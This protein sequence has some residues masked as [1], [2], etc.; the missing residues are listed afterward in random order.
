MRIG[1]VY[2]QVELQGDAVAMRQFALATERIGYD[3]LVCYDHLLGASH[4]G[5]E[6]K[7]YGHY[8]EH[9]P[10]HDPFM[11]FAHVAAITERIEFVTGV[12]VLPQRQ[13]VLVA[14]QSTDLDL[15]SNQRFRL[16]VGVGWN[17]V[18][19]QGLGQDFATRGKR[20]DEQI[21]LL[22]RLWT[23]PLVTHEGRFDRID[24]AALVPRPKRTIPIWIG[25]MSEPAY[26]RAARLGD[27]FIFNS[28]S[29]ETSDRATYMAM[30]RSRLATIDGFRREAGRQDA[31]FGKELQLRHARTHQETVQ[32]AKDWQDLGGTHVSVRTM[33]LGFA[34]VDEHIDYIDKVYHHLSTAL[35]S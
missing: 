7:L 21:A 11:L 28:G 12:L 19:Y 33:G 15:M 30:N 20:L 18:E 9:D 34:N 17:Y 8:D 3:H 29:V 27:G 2:P 35:K 31:A 32:M 5:R 14:R 4:E 1:V 16:G 10:F 6:P 24:R 23:E 25:G 13:T 26:R 22:R